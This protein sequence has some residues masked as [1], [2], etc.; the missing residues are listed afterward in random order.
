[1][2]WNAYH[3]RSK[4]YLRL[5]WEPETGGIMS[6]SAGIEYAYND[7]CTSEIAGIMHDEILKRNFTNVPAIGANYSILCRKAILI[8]DS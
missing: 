4:D 8:K 1:M 2:K 7:F 5:G 3:A 6:C